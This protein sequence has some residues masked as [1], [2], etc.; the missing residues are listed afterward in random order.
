MPEL[1]DELIA[2]AN[3]DTAKENAFLRQTASLSS[4]AGASAIAATTP[5]GNLR[6]F[7]RGKARYEEREV[8]EHM[9]VDGT[10]G[11]LKNEM[12]HNDRRGL[13]HYIA[14]HKPV[15]HPGGP[16]AVPHPTRAHRRHHEI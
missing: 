14:K 10:S 15:Q 13:E 4:S 5:A 11:Y 12:E 8:H 7:R 6:F 1:R 16:R 9:V 3:A 2:V